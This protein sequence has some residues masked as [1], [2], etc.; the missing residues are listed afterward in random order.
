MNTLYNPTN[1]MSMNEKEEEYL[2]QENPERFVI[3]P[4]QYQDFWDMYKQHKK[5]FWVAEEVDLTQDIFDWKNKLNDKERYFIS[6]VLAF[7]AGSDGIVTENLA[8]N[9]MKEIQ[10]PELRCFY[11]FQIAMENIHGEMYSDLIISLIQD[12]SE[13]KKLLRATETIP[14]IKQKADW[15]IKWIGGGEIYPN[16]L[17]PALLEDLKRNPSPETEKWL[18]R[19]KPSFARRLLAFACVEG[20]FFSGSFCAIFWMKDR[21]LMPGLCQSNELISR[22]EGLHQDAAAVVAS[23]LKHP[24]PEADAHAMVKE[25]VAIEKDF[26]TKSLPVDMINM[27]CLLMKQYIEYVADRL[28]VQFG[29]KKIWNSKQPFGFMEMIST[30]N[31]TQFFERRVTEYQKVIGNENQ[32]RFDLV[33]F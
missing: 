1:Q 16:E 11:G 5:A 15:A 19:Q 21:G 10:I 24:L 17:P 33:D 25:A 22:D 26:C 13:R 31:K 9:F 6:H 27:N 8:I 4:I 29:Y 32:I 20:I 28:L 3:K 30:Q 2:L 23:H 14:C 12:S 7:F 18:A